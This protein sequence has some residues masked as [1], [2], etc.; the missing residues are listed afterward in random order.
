MS[1]T[2]TVTVSE[3]VV[4]VPARV[5]LVG[6]PSDGYGGAVLAAVVD[7]L[8]ATVTAAALPHG[9]RIAHHDLG[10]LGWRSPASFLAEV[11]DRGHGGE[12]RIVTAAL[13]ALGRHRGSLPAVGIEW[14]TT[15]PRSVGLAGSS[16]IAIATIEAI[17]A[18]AGEQLDPRAVAALA[19]EAETVDLGIAAGW[20]D[21]MVQA[22][23]R[24]VL[25]DAAERTVVAGRSLPAVRTLDGVGLDAVVAWRAG[26]AQDSGRYH[27]SLRMRAGDA[28]IA[29]AMERLAALA[30]RAADAAIAGDGDRV[31]ELV[32]ASW[33]VRRAAMPLAPEHAAL[34][35]I[36]RAAGAAASSPGSGG[37]VVALPA[38]ASVTAAVVG[39]LTAAGAEVL[40]TRLG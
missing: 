13:A 38:D 3:T 22:H 39:A 32:D 10:V 35:E 11:G 2:V 21:R 25:V 29:D 6:N 37:S 14:V 28:G 9:L 12:Q 31:R 40:T 5:G 16:A 23:H 15:I 7:A 18:C 33:C 17:T 26:D 24:A 4:R 36:A 20:Q 34:V 19:L 30:R 1:G 8:G 27:A